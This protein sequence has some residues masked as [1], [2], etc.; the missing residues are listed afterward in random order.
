M[1][2]HRQVAPGLELRQLVL[3]D[4]AAIFAVVERNRVYLREWLPWV[5]R[6]LSADDIRGFL[7][8]VAEQH[9]DSL[10]PNAA[11]LLEGR[12]IGTVGCH[13]VDWNNRH[14]S[15]GYWIDG[16]QQGKGI[17]TRCCAGLVDYLFHDAGLHRVTI[18]CGTGNHKSCAIPQRL[19][20]TREGVMREAE[21][22]S[23]RWVNL[24][25]WGMLAPDWSAR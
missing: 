21:W 2:F 15:I 24:V 8:R 20:F 19:G 23:G 5:D 13:P 3:A 14:T 25:V 6:T 16:A 1:T 11:I 22:V 17:M 4:A 7:V 9:E 10:G 18:Q 12:F